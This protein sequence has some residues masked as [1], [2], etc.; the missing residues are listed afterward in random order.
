MPLTSKKV[1]QPTTR[2]PNEDPD[3]VGFGTTLAEI[4]ADLQDAYHARL[5]AFL[6]KY[7]LVR[8][9]A[10]VRRRIFA[11]VT[12]RGR[13]VDV[14]F[15]IT[16]YPPDASGFF[17]ADGA[18]K[19]PVAELTAETEPDEE[20]WDEHLPNQPPDDPEGVY[21]TSMFTGKPVW[22]AKPKRGWRKLGRRR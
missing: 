22:V 5:R 16:F 12:A 20:Q 21:I 1:S 14:D 11:A 6:L 7:L 8:L 19:T 3:P 18:L 4:I 2:S 10:A 17:R 13:P 15:R 9:D